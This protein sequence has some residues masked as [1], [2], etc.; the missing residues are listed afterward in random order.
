MEEERGE[1]RRRERGEERGEEEEEAAPPPPH[2]CS[3][4]CSV[5]EFMKKTSPSFLHPPADQSRRLI[6][7]FFL[8]PSWLAVV[9]LQATEP[10]TSPCRLN[11]T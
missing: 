2:S 3:I 4:I 9:S 1:D 6:D 11:E 7:S 10:R 5:L 8:P